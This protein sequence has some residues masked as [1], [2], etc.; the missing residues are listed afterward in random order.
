MKCYFCEKEFESNKHTKQTITFMGKEVS[1]C[2]EC[3]KLYQQMES[4]KLTNKD[5]LLYFSA[6]L[7][8]DTK[9]S[10]VLE[11]MDKYIAEAL[12]ENDKYFQK[13][14]ERGEVEKHE[15][16]KCYYCGNYNLKEEEYCMSCFKKDYG[17]AKFGE[18][19]DLIFYTSK[20][21]PRLETNQAFE[22]STFSHNLIWLIPLAI[23]CLF[24][25]G[26]VLALTVIIGFTVWGLSGQKSYDEY[27]IKSDDKRIRN[28]L[29]LCEV[30]ARKSAKENR[31]I[32]KRVLKQQEFL[33]QIRLLHYYIHR[34]YKNECDNIQ[35]DIKLVWTGK[36]YIYA[37]EEKRMKRLKKLNDTYNTS[38]KLL[39]NWSKEQYEIV[40]AKYPYD[41]YLSPL[42]DFEKYLNSY[43]YGVP[44][45]DCERMLTP[46][47]TK[48]IKKLLDKITTKK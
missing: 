4:N 9:N 21:N 11:A 31:E 38:W 47:K 6:R 5:A 42:R 30:N 14:I 43:A 22:L 10:K 40:A 45:D 46:E 44:D 41:S 23:L 39:N 7:T 3:I 34:E 1:I 27:Y 35:S 17:K 2:K 29:R 24:L 28:D 20:T 48:E 19:H 18:E 15:L 33:D 37:N 13:R 12:E 36:D 32:L 25:T 8:D 16:W 26:Q